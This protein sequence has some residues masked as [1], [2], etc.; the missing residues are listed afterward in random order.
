MEEMFWPL[1]IATLILSP[2]GMVST[3]VSRSNVPD[4]LSGNTYSTIGVSFAI[5]NEPVE[6]SLST[7]LK[8]P[9]LVLVYPVLLVPLRIRYTLAGS[10][11]WNATLSVLSL[12]IRRLILF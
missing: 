2:G 6:V 8:V 9:M 12:T 11:P 7:L 4:P 10:L 5:V 1:L 3:S